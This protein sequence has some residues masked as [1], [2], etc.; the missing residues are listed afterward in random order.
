MTG[1]LNQFSILTRKRGGHSILTLNGLKFDN[2]SVSYSLCEG[3]FCARPPIH[4]MHVLSPKVFYH[5]P[6]Y[7]MRDRHPAFDIWAAT[8]SAGFIFKKNK[9]GIWNINCFRSV[10][11]KAV[12][13]LFHNYI[14]RTQADIYSCNQT[15]HH[16]MF[17]R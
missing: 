2:S 11:V 9:H 16:C 4:N 1:F 12:T 15:V 13:H 7:D 5:T 10:I 14:H 17:H 3:S 8:L 6:I